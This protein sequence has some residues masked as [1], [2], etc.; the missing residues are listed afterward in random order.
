MSIDTACSSGL[1]A[2]DAAYKAANT[3][4]ENASRLRQQAE[5]VLSRIGDTQPKNVRQ[6]RALGGVM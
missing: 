4:K 2:V 3:D 1:V 6:A 5:T